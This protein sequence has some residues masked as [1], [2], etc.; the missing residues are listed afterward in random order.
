MAVFVGMVA[1]FLPKLTRRRMLGESLVAEGAI[2]R[3]Q[4]AAALEHQERKGF[5]LGYHLIK[6]GYID[7][8]ALGEF[9][10]R[11][12]EVP[13]LDEQ[14]LHLHTEL[15]RDI[16]DDV[17]R[18]YE[19][20]PLHRLGDTLT[21]VMAD[22]SD[23]EAIHSIEKDLAVRVMPVV[24][25]QSVIQKHLAHYFALQNI[26]EKLGTGDES[27]DV[28]RFFTQLRDYRFQS[29]LGVGGF[30][31]VCKCWQISLDRPVAVKTMN[32]RLSQMP[33]MADRFKREGKIIARLNHPNIIQVYEQ[34]EA[35]GLLYI[36][37]QFFEGK[38]LDA[39]CKGKD[40]VEKIGCL[41]PMCDALH[42]AERNGVIHR[43]VKP[44]NMLANDA[45]EVKLLDFGVA[46]FDEPQDSRI[47]QHNMVLGTPKYM[48]PECF[49]GAAHVTT[50]SDIYSMGVVAYEFF[51]E[52]EFSQDDRV[53]PHVANPD[54]P[55]LLS[56][57]VMKALEPDPRKRLR[58]F[59][60]FKRAL[61]YSR[62]QLL[63]GQ[64][65]MGA[66]RAA[67]N[68]PTPGDSAEPE[69][70]SMESCY[71]EEQVLRDDEEGRLVLARHTRMNRRVVIRRVSPRHLDQDILTRLSDI[72][73]PGIGEI[74]GSGVDGESIVVINEYYEGG[75]LADRM[76]AGPVSPEEFV[77]WCDEMVAALE[78]ARQ[79]GVAHGRLHPGNIL[80]T[81]KG[82]LKIVDFGMRGN[83]S[84]TFARYTRPEI[85][86]P[87]ER[88]RYALGVIWF[89]MLAGERFRGAQSYEQNFRKVQEN[90]QIESLLK[91]PLG[92]LWGI[93]RYGRKYDSYTDM[94]EDLQFV[95]EKIKPAIS[96]A[97][98]AARDSKPQAA[99]APARGAGFYVFLGILLLLATLAAGAVSY[100]L[101]RVAD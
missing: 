2:T 90:R 98:G 10:A 30:G 75:T 57:T 95:R 37:M 78:T 76:Q 100:L 22:P 53:A 82:Q 26:G 50:L 61:A 1:T 59:D 86:D 14:S 15:F 12:Y 54:V 73:H 80:F 65:V 25:P 64:T 97:V 68:G 67:T 52:R 27:Q 33:G 79:R 46:F 41:V 88:D 11:R 89:E 31:M 19:I 36:V 70:R 71:E 83:R 62:D 42:Y 69:A 47:T 28:T 92:R 66:A 91:V 43:D 55:R 8:A 58:S 94:G 101:T 84:T 9:L 38:P 63:M 93:A 35:A 44:A 34:G 3:E 4:L 45:G 72:K 29:V 48:A 51:A 40:L 16:D 6:L 32:R 24:A 5:R 77:V 13:A 81:A 18:N 23:T 39:F 60:L 7:E 99:S 17:L 56:Q 74:L 20:F 96:T 87:W 49:K 85:T 21:L